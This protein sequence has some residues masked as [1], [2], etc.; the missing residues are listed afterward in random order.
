M[1]G[2]FFWYDLMTTDTVAAAKFYGAVVGWGTKDSGSNDYTLFTID[3]AGLLGL[4][5]M[6]KE[7]SDAGAKPCWLG[8]VRVDDVDAA[9]A[10]IE[11]LGGKMMRPPT[12]VPDIIRFCPVTDPHG[13]G[14]MIAKP[15]PGGA[16][17]KLPPHHVGTVGWRE[18]YAGDGAKAFAFYSEAFGWTRGDT[19]DM[20]PMG[21]YQ[22]FKTPGD[23]DVVGGIMTK[24]PHA[25]MAYWS[26]YFNV[27]ALDAAAKRVADHG[28][29]ILHGPVEVPGGSWIVQCADPQGAIFAL[30]APKR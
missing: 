9:A 5:P 26:Y 12:L 13:A 23:G 29:K 19:V 16:L 24:P 4:M 14:F 15:M 1:Q 10:R 22:L 25:P 17:P 7:M 6:P 27:E 18:L 11:K 28:G 20:G 8:Y 3:G 30:I 2:N 21:I